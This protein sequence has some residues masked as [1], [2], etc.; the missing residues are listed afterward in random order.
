MV[1]RLTPLDLSGLDQTPDPSARLSSAEELAD[2]L[3]Q[4]RQQSATMTP[5]PSLTP[6]SISQITFQEDEAD[7]PVLRI[8]TTLYFIRD[9]DEVA[10]AASA[11]V[12]N[13]LWPKEKRDK[14]DFETKKLFH[15]AVTQLVLPKN[16]KLSLPNY[17]TNDDGTLQGVHHRSNQIHNIDDR[18]GVLDLADVFNIVVPGDLANGPTLRPGS[19]YLFDDYLRLTAAHVANSN[20]WWRT[21]VKAPWVVEN[22]QLSFEFLKAHVHAPLWDKCME[23]Y[24]T[25]NEKQQGGPLMAFLVLERIQNRSESAIL[26]LQAKTKTLS[27]KQIPNEDVDVAVS[28]IKDAYKA[29]LNASRPDKS[30]IPDDFPETIFKIF[31]T[32]STPQ[33]NQVFSKMHDELQTRADM[34]GTLPEWPSVSSLTNLATKTY[35]RLLVED[36]WIKPTS[37]TALLGET[38]GHTRPRGKCFNCGEDHL[39][40]KCTKPRDEAKIKAARD[41]FAANR[42][43][44]GRPGGKSQGGPPKRKFGPGGRPLVLNK[45]GAYVTDTKR[46]QEM[47]AKAK[48]DATTAADTVFKSF[49]ASSTPS[50]Q[51]TAPTAPVSALTDDVTVSFNRSA[52]IAAVA[53]ARSS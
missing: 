8:G 15:E 27:L 39:L 40:P 18:L 16:D 11:P 22:M 28:Y 42:P 41:A 48:S 51:S 45:Q 53:R 10:K 5:R 12:S 19:Y 46:W 52:F 30:F 33:F 44:S 6:R 20:V 25:Y 49:L 26:L 2:S 38:S 1:T 3:R 7:K 31:Q 50:V 24:R 17:K 23:D 34:L 47:K 9:P 43:N 13:V 36:A 29:F 21:Y 14:F 32:T 37:P 35:Q 4:F